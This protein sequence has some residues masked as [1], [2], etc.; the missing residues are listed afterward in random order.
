MMKNRIKQ[1]KGITMI[2]LVIIVIM[3]L[4]LTNVLVYNA[5]DSFHIQALN[6]LYSDIELLRNKVSE[7]YNE[8]GE[9]PAKI[10]YTNIKQL[11]QANILSNNN[12][13]INSFYVI[14]LEAMQGITTNY[15]KDY[16]KIKDNSEDANKYTDLY[17]INKNSHNI[18]YVQGIGIEQN[19]EIKVYYTDYTSPDETIVDLR[20]ID[21]ILIPEGYYYIGKT[22]DNS[23]NESLVISPNKDDKIDSKSDIQYIWQKQISIME[24]VPDSITL[25]EDDGQDVYEF[26]KSTNHFKGYFLNQNTKQVLYLSVKE[27]KWS[28]EYTENGKYTDK[29]GD[30]AYVPSGFRV[31]LAEGTNEIRSGLVITDSINE[32][33]YSTGNEFVWIPVEDF[34]EF[35]R[36]DFGENQLTE[37]Y[38]TSEALAD[39]LYYEPIGDGKTID[40]K[41]KENIQEIQKVYASVKKYR[42]FYIGRYETGIEGVTERT[43]TSK[44]D[45]NPVIKKNKLIYNYIPWGNSMIDENGGA[46][47]VARNMYENSTLC[48]GV[49]WD[50]IMR[51]INQDSS[52]NYILTDSSTNGNYDES[53]EL[54]KTGNYE[55]YQVKNIYDLAGNVSEWTMESYGISEK[56]ARGGKSGNKENIT[57]RESEGL[58]Y[59]SG[60]CGFRVA[61]YIKL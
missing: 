48:Y 12:D 43:N 51:W 22:K 49:Q 3:L 41:A 52:I 53:S 46:V 26:I 30:I 8:Y 44:L 2:A 23:G 28:E 56:V 18:F 25:M 17:I 7:Y 9:I 58:S 54:I 42:G 57:Y 47:Q 29:N 60:L 39:E 11:Q 10:Q 19:N 38:F 36:R 59:T 5:R 1:E 14:D 33:G 6:D 16:E 4:I 21:N 45:E 20:Y 61:L 24:K 27:N 31:S 13:L 15:G 55:E 32:E 35:V 50:A 37:E 40:E 34:Y